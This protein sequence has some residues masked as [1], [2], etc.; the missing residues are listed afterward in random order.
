MYK[1]H[2]LQ[3]CQEA[4]EHLKPGKNSRKLQRFSKNSEKTWKK[5]KTR[6]FVKPR[7]YSSSDHRRLR[8][9]FVDFQGKKEIIVKIPAPVGGEYALGEKWNKFTRATCEKMTELMQKGV[10][11][12]VVGK[13]SSTRP[14]DTFVS[15]AIVMDCFQAFFEYTMRFSCGISKVHFLGTQDDWNLL[16]VKLAG[17][18]K[19]EGEKGDGS[20]AQYVDNLV[21]VFTKFAETFAGRVDSSWWNGVIDERHAQGYGSGAPAELSGWILRFY[22][23]LGAKVEDTEDMTEMFARVPVTIDDHDTRIIKVKIFTGF[24]GIA[25]ASAENCAEDPRRQVF[26]PHKSL[27]VILE[28]PSDDQPKTEPEGCV[29]QSGQS[30]QK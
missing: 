20:W 30:R 4:R 29:Q 9:L 6:G 13:F 11:N 1:I 23:G 22:Y 14:F 12:D 24:S 21:P 26:R 25:I 28:C 5:S 19:Y 8:S 3:K 18:R 2:T 27:A 10:V 16:P 7:V 15:Q 17:L